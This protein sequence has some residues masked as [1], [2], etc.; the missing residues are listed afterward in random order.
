MDRALKVRVVLPLAVFFVLAS[1]VALRM[2]PTIDELPHLRYGKNV[3][4]GQPDRDEVWQNSKMPVTALN[5]GPRAVAKL[6]EAAD[7]LPGAAAALSDL[8]A[9][10]FVT[11]AWALLLGFLVGRWAAALYGPG[12]GLAAMVLFALSPNLVAHAT[13]A[14]TDLYVSLGFF[15]TL[16]ALWRMVREPSTRWAMTAAAALALAQITKTSALFLYPIAVAVVLPV[17]W[18]RRGREKWVLRKAAIQFVVCA[19]VFTLVALNVSFLFR[20]TFTP[21]AD[22]EFDSRAVSIPPTDSRRLVDP[23]AAAAPVSDRNRYVAPCS[24]SSAWL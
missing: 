14:T 10:R 19:A 6:L 13:L 18:I 3:L 5:V 17:V 12:A 2:A 8:R 9:A 4:Q 23:T 15:A 21:L 7:V 16:Y 22:Y 20:G 24:G 1:T 11:I